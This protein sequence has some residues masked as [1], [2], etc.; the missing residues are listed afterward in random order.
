[1]KPN[2]TKAFAGLIA[3]C[4]L[5]ATPAALLAE[6]AL[7]PPAHEIVCQEFQGKD[8]KACR[9][10]CTTWP[11]SRDC[12]L[13]V[14]FGF[15][16]MAAFNAAKA[17]D[18]PESAATKLGMKAAEA[19]RFLLFLEAFDLYKHQW[20]VDK[21]RDAKT[22]ALHQEGLKKLTEAQGLIQ[23]KAFAQAIAAINQSIATLEKTVGND[24]PMVAAA[25]SLR[26]WA[27]EQKGDGKAAVAS[28]RRAE[29]IYRKV[30]GPSHPLVASQLFRLATVLYAMDKKNDARK[31]FQQDID[32]YNEVYGRINLASAA[33]LNQLALWSSAEGDLATSQKH[34]GTLLGIYERTHGPEHSQLV[35]PLLHLAQVHQAQQQL[36]RALVVTTRALAIQGKTV[37]ADHPNMGHLVFTLASVYHAKGDYAR[38]VSL[39]ER[40]LAIEEKA[41]GKDRVEVALTLNSLALAYEAMGNL[42]RALPIF[43]RAL[44]ITETT[45]GDDNHHVGAILNN[46]AIVYKARGE[47]AKALPMYQRALSIQEKFYGKDHLQLTSIL[48]NIALLYQDQ[49]DYDRALP[50]LQ[51]SLAIREKALGKD[52]PE[53]GGS[54]NNLAELYKLKGDF[55]PVLSMY[56]RA[57]TIFKKSLG[58]THPKVAITLNNM[59]DLYTRQGAYDQALIHLQRSLVISEKNHGKDHLSN[60][61]VLNNLALVHSL[62]GKVD[63]AIRL[64]KQALTIREQ[65]QGKDHP[66][67]AQVLN[68][69]GWNY[70][71]KGDFDRALALIQRSVLIRK[72]AF[73]K[74][75][76]QVAISL[77]LLAGVY[78]AK[79]DYQRALSVYQRTLAIREKALGKEHPDVA[80]ALNNIAGTYREGSA[81][82]QALP[83]YQRALTIYEKTLGKDHPH[84]A[85][86]LN[87][88][89]I[90][91]DGK[92]DF[93]RAAALYRQ[94]LRIQE[95]S[96]G[97]DHPELARTLNNLAH[98]Y[99]DK[100]AYKRSLK[101][102]QRSLAI[103]EKALGPE[104]PQRALMI[105]NI[106]TL[107]WAMGKPQEALADLQLAMTVE[108]AHMERNLARGTAREHLLLVKSFEGSLDRVITLV[109]SLGA[110]HEDA[111][112]FGAK[113]V[114]LAKARATGASLRISRN[115]RRQ[116]ALFHGVQKIQSQLS[117]ISYRKD[118]DPEKIDA[119][120]TR[121]ETLQQRM[122]SVGRQSEA[123]VKPS[124]AG[125]KRL[126]NEKTA[127]VEWVVYKPFDPGT[128]YSGTRYGKPHLAAVVIRPG[129]VPQWFGLGELD[130]LQPAMEKLRSAIAK[131]RWDFK[132]ASQ[133]LTRRIFSP[134]EPALEGIDTLILSPDGPLH[135]VP[136][137]ALVDDQGRW[138][139]A[140][141]QLRE[142]TTARDVFQLADKAFE[143][144]EPPLVLADAHFDR[145]N[146]SEIAQDSGQ[147][148]VS[149]AV[150]AGLRM[151]RL[152][153]TRAEAETVGKLFA[154]P[155]NRI[156]LGAQAS[157]HALR[158]VKGPA[159][160]HIA[161]HGFFLA[162]NQ[163][164]DSDQAH[165]S[166]DAMLLSG[167]T[168]A[169]FNS[170]NEAPHPDD[171]GLL[172]A[173]ELGGLDL[174][175]T[176][177]VVLSAC[178]TGLG[179]V[180]TGEGVFGLKRALT[181]AGSRTQIVSLWKVDDKA[182]QALMTAYYGR[183]LKGEDR[184]EALRQVQLDML[185]G[186]L[187]ESADVVPDE[188][189]DVLVGWR[190]PYYWAAFVV[191]GAA[192]PIS[193]AQ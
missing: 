51:Q 65:A 84:L 25:F 78:K 187:A 90:V 149:T 42:D 142:V 55:P 44:T 29:A 24:H 23:S 162:G 73:G 115:T 19:H 107:K 69:L 168:L 63:Q 3:W 113:M 179:E 145:T 192:G 26:G 57:L 85:L 163:D 10:A 87:N 104:H 185:H 170:R 164:T 9:S 43:Q 132:A 37:G 13:V 134:L 15:R 120:K 71:N 161:T 38:A 191:S 136:F 158:S 2:K 22:E 114:L 49:A 140:R 48:N 127:L 139:S 101:M 98:N 99:K 112:D 17:G 166:D 12:M 105:D 181:L 111:R 150:M 11:V 103:T 152:M 60:A 77:N 91:Y 167:L 53:V 180:E 102:Y 66:L 184:V 32:I 160:L 100:K 4:W 189:D 159:F 76:L 75:H 144:R 61:G 96:L 153:G 94:T 193:F 92:G 165:A 188:S 67:I 18:N 33:V 56:Q 80:I 46:M 8:L 86:T 148:G 128:K 172:T 62:Q 176:E 178:E 138:L 34:L 133:P 64:Y 117:A 74:D 110:A 14:R 147:R 186:R 135:T 39:F 118:S 151:R 89:A 52:H 108:H 126:M 169:G 79:G 190:N 156:K 31:A 54:L 93:D 40:T 116:M 5:A 174:Y 35:Q 130:S 7:P 137:A 59:G 124:I 141:F 21:P 72:K 58:K 119:L 95:K 41:L 171:D 154:L 81:P 20:V 28:Y 27:Q 97:K 175:G 106:A 157:E 88:M 16:G 1:M 45:Y 83:L 30:C 183:L 177:L 68:N 122:A 143:P 155:T 70:H 109:L 129:Q 173:L 123:D 6:E 146:P 82:D 121:L 131:Q 182:T 125:L 50:L 36:D 47:Y